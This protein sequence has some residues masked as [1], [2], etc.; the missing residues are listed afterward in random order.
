M[1]AATLLAVLLSSSAM[2]QGGALFDNVTQ[3]LE[4]RF[5]DRGFR[6]HELP[7][8]AVR[9]RPAA[10]RATS[11]AEEREAVHALLSEIPASH[12][13][14]YSAA[15]YRSLRRALGGERG[16]T[17]GFQLER[18]PE[19]FFVTA[20]WEGGPAERSGLRAGDRVLQIDGTPTANSA[21]VDWRSD[22]A[23][24]D[25]AQRHD[26]LGEAGDAIALEVERWPG[27]VDRVRIAAQRYSALDAARASVH[28]LERDGL[29]FGYLHMW[30][31]HYRG[32]PELLL[33]AIRREFAGCDGIV[34]DLRGRGGS[35]QAVRQVARVLERHWDRPLVALI[36]QETRSAKEL[37]AD[38]IRRRELGVLVGERTAGAVIPASF[39]QVGPESWLMFPASDL[40]DATERLELVGVIPD[41]FAAAAGP[42][43]SGA[44]PILERG[45]VEL[46]RR[47]GEGR[48]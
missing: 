16:P 1:K 10:E 4:L 12:L 5:F 30:Y 39:E 47:V 3:V 40:G 37:L 43:A 14:L 8:L 35:A 21:R 11:L 31:M 28:V 22:D 48:A 17:F 45:L 24:L 2:A 44:D 15:T 32:L 23:Y 46:V 26:V 38:A 33:G 36:D 6:R 42:Y 9:H 20:V 34:L 7:E 27:E 25:D 19:G 41:V 13:A 18:R 29:R